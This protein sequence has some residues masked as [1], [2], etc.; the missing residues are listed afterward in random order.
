MNSYDQG[1]IHVHF[2]L[3]IKTES[4]D[5]AIKVLND[6]SIDHKVIE[7]I[8]INMQ[9]EK[10]LYFKD[11]EDNVVEFYTLDMKED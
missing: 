9:K 1:G 2:A 6:A 10:R 7:E 3:H 4:F 5:S 11:T 8:N